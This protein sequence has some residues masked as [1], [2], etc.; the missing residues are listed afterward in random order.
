ML[1]DF[2]HSGLVLNKVPLSDYNALRKYLESLPDVN[3]FDNYMFI[4]SSIDETEPGGRLHDEL[5]VEITAI[6]SQRLD[7]KKMDVTSKKMETRRKTTKIKGNVIDL[8]WT[9]YR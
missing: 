4:G 1:T 2:N 8:S 7:Q 9:M 5:L 6:T 3:I